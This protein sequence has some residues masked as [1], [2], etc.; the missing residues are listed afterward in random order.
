M[1]LKKLFLVLAAFAVIGFCFAALTSCSKKSTATTGS[2]S[3]AKLTAA[4]LEN[5]SGTLEYWSCF[6]A[7]SLIWDQ[8]RVAEFEKKYPNVKV[9]LQSVPESAGIGNGKLLSAIASGN[10]PDVIVA[11][12]F[13]TAYGYAGQGAFESWDPYMDAIQLNV[14]DFMPGFNG[15]MQ[16]KGVTYLL[17]Q[18]SN[19]YFMFINTELADAAGLDYVNDYPKT[20]EELDAWADKLTIKDSS[21]N[22]TQYGFIPWTDRG[23]DEPTTWPF[24][25]G[26][27]I[28][29][30]S[31]NKLELTDPRVI[32]AYKWQASYAKKFDP[33]VAKAVSQAAGG[34]FS[35]AH[36]FFNNKLAITISGNWTTNAIRIYAPHVKYVVRP[37]PVPPGGR[38]GAT[39]LGSNVFAI[40]KGSKRPDLAALFFKF[41]QEAYINADNF[42]QWRSIPCVDK[43]FD[44]VSW[45]KAG[46]EIYALERVLA[47]NPKTAHPAL[48]AVSAELS[49]Q[50]ANVRDETI[51][52]GRDPL[53]LLQDIQNR[54]QPELDKAA[55]AK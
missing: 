23:N 54:L 50:L 37:I 44:D 26:A 42:D 38:E 31:T 12:D 48:C 47:N 45:T 3:G 10:P 41:T 49:K 46:D 7:D 30:A 27:E 16:Y 43:I 28:Y 19:V 22:V 52:S 1:K 6:T 55:Q 8:W 51:Y 11:D 5:A 39:T 20:M 18:D 25:F 36:P 2:S 35:P 33:T 4:E 15:L 9:N 24:M 14:N 13:V 21:G 17:P 34:F 29:N 32:D 40:P 53:P